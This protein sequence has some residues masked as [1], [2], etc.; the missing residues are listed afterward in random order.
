MGRATEME[1][2]RRSGANDKVGF[3]GDR[4]RTQEEKERGGGEQRLYGGTTVI[5]AARA[6]GRITSDEKHG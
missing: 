6:A 3:D 2:G 1:I 4:A 5:E